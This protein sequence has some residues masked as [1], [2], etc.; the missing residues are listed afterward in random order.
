M[1]RA[2]S[3]H[4]GDEN[5][6]AGSKRKASENDDE[7]DETNNQRRA[8]DLTSAV[9]RKVKEKKAPARMA[10]LEAVTQGKDT[11]AKAMTHTGESSTAPSADTTA[12]PV[13]ASKKR[14]S[15]KSLEE[16]IVEYKQNLDHIN[17]DGIVIGSRNNSVNKFL[18]KTGPSEGAKSDVFRTA[19]RLEASNGTVAGGSGATSK[20][21]TIPDISNIYIEGEDSDEVPSF[22]TCD[23][24]R[25]TTDAYLKTPGLTQA[26]FCRDLYAQLRCPTV[27]AIQSKSLNDFRGKKGA[28]AGCPSTIF[29]AAYVYFEKFRFA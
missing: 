21:T 19:W 18:K 14:K 13:P 9:L 22:D 27:A 12:P 2:N 7:L 8:E 29:Y 25:K 28:R 4:H 23:E 3:A 20:S 11:E 15:A 16:D 5:Q 10:K 17:V 24:I 6:V 26:Q 1:P